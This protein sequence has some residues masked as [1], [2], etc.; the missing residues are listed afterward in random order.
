MTKRKIQIVLNPD[1]LAMR[2]ESFIKVFLDIR[3]NINSDV[4]F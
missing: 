2:I 3:T 4:K 1:C